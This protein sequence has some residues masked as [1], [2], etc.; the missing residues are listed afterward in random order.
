ALVAARTDC[1]VVSD[2]RRADCAAGG[3]G[4]PLVPF[5]DYVLFRHPKRSR[6]LLNI[7]G[8]ANVTYLPAGGSIHEVVAFDTGPGNC[9][10]DE[11]FRRHA[12]CGSG[13]DDRGSG[14]ARGRAIAGVVEAVLGDAYFSKAPP[15]ST[16]GPA[17][18]SLFDRAAG[19]HASD[20]SFNDRL[21]TAC[22]ITARAV[23][24]SA[25]RAEEVFASGGGVYN[26]TLMARL[27]EE[28][29]RPRPIRDAGGD[30]DGAA[31][32]AVAFA[33]LAAATLDG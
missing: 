20:A 17:M 15:K 7:G 14:A 30:F 18:I 22:V 21:A 2:F 26:E 25:P 6:L 9:I 13:Y 16:D 11:L 28:G 24:R 3:Q 23:A 4:A 12:P 5:A 10:S 1:A 27:V 31:K 33:L 8:I 19:A 32:E 29:I